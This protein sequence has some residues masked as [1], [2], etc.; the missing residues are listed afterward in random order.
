MID[1]KPEVLQALRNNAA[2]VTI[3]GG[4]KIWP[5]IVPDDPEKPVTAPYVTFVELTNFD[6]D[7]A[8]DRAMTSEIHY[9]IDVWSPSDTG[10][11]TIEVNKVME[12]LGFVRTGAIDRYDTVSRLYHKVLRYKTI[13]RR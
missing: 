6:K 1:L 2:L 5:E 8:D 4:K 12:E 11:S 7:Y 3:L 9:Q 10:P 13:V